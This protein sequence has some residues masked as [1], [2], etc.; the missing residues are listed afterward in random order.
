MDKN[1]IEN[2]EI[3]SFIDEAVNKK[4]SRLKRELLVKNIVMAVS[5]FILI[6]VLVTAVTRTNN[7]SPGD[8][9]ESAKINNDFNTV[10][11]AVNA[12]ASQVASLN[13]VPVGTIVPWYNANGVLSVPDGWQLCDG[14]KINVTSGPLLNHYTPNLTGETYLSGVAGD[15][16]WTTAP[17]TVGFNTKSL[18]V[19]VPSHRHSHNLSIVNSGAHEHYYYRAG[20]TG[21]VYGVSIAI[22]DKGSGIYTETLGGTGGIHSHTISGD[23]GSGTTSGDSNFSASGSNDIRPKTINVKYIMKIHEQ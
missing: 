17:G 7:Y 12:L 23:V 19:S 3:L 2:Q 22:S 15:L 18:I 6:P 5:F 9:I 1:R 11:D 21:E 16:N 8:I 4:F 10:Y 20:G 13:Q 14:S